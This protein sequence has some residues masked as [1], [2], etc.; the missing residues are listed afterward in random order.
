M[1]R[2]IPSDDT[3]SDNFRVLEAQM[4]KIFA[5]RYVKQIVLTFKKAGLNCEIVKFKQQIDNADVFL[6]VEGIPMRLI[7]NSRMI[8][9]SRPIILKECPEFNLLESKVFNEIFK[10]SNFHSV[11]AVVEYFQKYDIVNLINLKLRAPGKM[12]MFERVKTFKDFNI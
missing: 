1:A 4:K 6:K 2:K 7:E 11:T 12:G 9:Q 5:D 10:Q 8:F 3:L